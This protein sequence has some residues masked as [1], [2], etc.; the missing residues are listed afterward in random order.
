MG[1]KMVTRAMRVWVLKAKPK[2]T[3]NLLATGQW[4]YNIQAQKT[5]IFRSNQSWTRLGICRTEICRLRF[6]RLWGM[7]LWRT[8]DIEGW[9]DMLPEFGGELL[10]QCRQLYDWSSDGV[11]TYRNTDFSVLVNGLN[12]AVQYQGNN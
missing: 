7:K 1:R 8:Y 5:P 12:F 2:L 10:H 9:T 11:A 6:F 4:K 3:I